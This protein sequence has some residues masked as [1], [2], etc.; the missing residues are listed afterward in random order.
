MLKCFIC[1]Y[2]NIEAGEVLRRSGG[3]EFEKHFYK[4]V[5]FIS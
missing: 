4:N 5:L 1:L 2:S 3:V